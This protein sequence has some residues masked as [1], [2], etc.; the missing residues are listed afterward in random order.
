MAKLKFNNPLFNTFKHVVVAAFGVVSVYTMIGLY[1]AFF[2]GIGYLIIKKYNKPNTK[3]LKD[4]QTGQYLGLVFVFLG[5]LPFFKY[6]FMGFALEG[7]SAT[8]DSI[9]GE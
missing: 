1:S 7:G 2:T 5:L 4:L 3:L 8:F 6:F 9:M